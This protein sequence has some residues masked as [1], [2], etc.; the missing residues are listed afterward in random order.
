[1]GDF[2]ENFIGLDDVYAE[3]TTKNIYLIFNTF[4]PKRCGVDDQIF[5]R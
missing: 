2:I 3:I 1:M 4:W 5:A